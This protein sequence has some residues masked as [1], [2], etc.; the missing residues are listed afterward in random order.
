MLPLGGMTSPKE[1][2]LSSH[3][4]NLTTTYCIK[5]HDYFVC[6]AKKHMEYDRQLFSIP[7]L[8]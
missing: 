5:E 2:G 7:V 1:T 3:V 6:P 8:C 4:K